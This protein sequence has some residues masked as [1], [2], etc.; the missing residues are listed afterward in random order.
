MNIRNNPAR[1]HYWGRWNQ[2]ML[3]TSVWEEFADTSIIKEMCPKIRGWIKILH[4]HYYIL[5]EDIDILARTIQKDRNA[6]FRRLFHLCDQNT[7]QLLSF[8]GS[9]QEY[10]NRLTDYLGCSFLVEQADLCLEKTLQKIAKKHNVEPGRIMM[11]MHPKRQTL[12]MNYK[13]ALR[14]IT[15]RKDFLKEWAWVTTHAF[16][17][18]PMT[19]D[20]IPAHATNKTGQKKK[21]KQE[22]DNPGK[23]KFP[24]EIQELIDIGSTLT[25]HRSN[26][27]ETA[28]KVNFRYREEMEELGKKDNLS[29]FDI[30]SMTHREMISY[31]DNRT[32]PKD[33][34]V[35]KKRFGV[36]YIDRKEEILLGDELDKELWIHEQKIKDTRIR[37]T[38]ASRGIARGKVKIVKSSDDLQKI[39]QGDIFVTTETMPDYINAMQKASGFITDQGGITCHAAVTAREM[40]KPCIIGTRIATKVLKEKELVELD[41]EKGTVRILSKTRL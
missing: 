16:E 14:S 13:S 4:G 15:D 28:N 8:H 41:A 3:F 10:I 17:G 11:Q 21:I 1:W 24:K 6:W 9:I 29:Y 33:L 2:V 7:E 5:K 25:F 39:K 35:R 18:K 36:V 30:I 12:L 31:I 19:K 22:Q 40:N 32:I 23:T 20:S 37:G 26:L 38:V 34:K 27:M